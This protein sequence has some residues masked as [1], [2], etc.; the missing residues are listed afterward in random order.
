MQLQDIIIDEW[1]K[2][3]T[4]HLMNLMCDLIEVM[5]G[6]HGVCEYLELALREIDGYAELTADDYLDYYDSYPY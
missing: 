2:A 6:I 4:Q 5:D 1:I 3:D